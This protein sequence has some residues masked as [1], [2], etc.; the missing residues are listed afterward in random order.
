[1]REGDGGSKPA[2]PTL[3]FRSC[4]CRGKL[5]D[6]WGELRREREKRL[7]LEVGGVRVPDGR[8]WRLA[9]P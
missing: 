1:M 2:R 9:A 3:P 5:V 8:G 7:L 4:I 6:I